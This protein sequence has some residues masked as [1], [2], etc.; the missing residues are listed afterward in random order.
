MTTGERVSSAAAARSRRFALLPAVALL[1]LLLFSCGGGEGEQDRRQEGGAQSREREVVRIAYV[2]WSSSVA[3]ANVAKAVL[4]EQLGYRVE[5]MP[6]SA[7]GMWRRVADG[8]ADAMLSAWLPK[9]HREY[10][11]EYRG[12]AE[13]LGANLSGVRTGLVVPRV[14]VGRQTAGSGLR[15]TPYIPVTTI[16]ELHDYREEFSGRIVGIDRGAGIMQRSREALEAYSLGDSYRLVAGSEETMLE[17]LSAAIASQQWIVVTGWTPHWAF[18]RWN[19]EFLDDPK[20][21]YGEEEEIHTVVRRGLRAELPAAY[22]FLD[23]FRWRSSDI[24]QIMLWN[25]DERRTFA[26]ENA[27]RWIKTHSNR[28]E[29]WVG[30]RSRR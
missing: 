11:A 25:H 21:I 30:E 8:S 10:L 1:S 2:E 19:L 17:E 16:P 7:E 20:N 5:L 6:E 13:D 18:S 23:A 24:G 15:N 14:T 27:V 12:E 22:D 28:V 29:E 9:T 3:S 26:Y 4:Q